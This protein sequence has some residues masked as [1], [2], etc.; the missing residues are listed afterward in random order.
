MLLP[1]SV[2]VFV[3]LMGPD[4]ALRQAAE[5]SPVNAAS[6]YLS[7]N[8]SELSVLSLSHF[9][10]FIPKVLSPVWQGSMNTVFFTMSDT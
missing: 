4:V 9:V 2:G 3:H 7:V 10:L 1:R 5:L 6:L 8:W